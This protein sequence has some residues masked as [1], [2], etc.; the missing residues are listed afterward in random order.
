MNKNFIFFLKFFR[1]R[2]SEMSDTTSK[3]IFIQ[4]LLDTIINEGDKLKLH[5]AVKAY[6]E[7]E[8]N[9]NFF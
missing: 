8:V 5:A 7:P 6:P 1:C 3:P 2:E 4:P 9:I